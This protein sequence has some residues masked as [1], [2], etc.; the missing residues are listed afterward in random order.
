MAEQSSTK[1]VVAA[2]L[3]NM[4]IAVT[5]FGAALYTGSSAML[6]EAV[7]S[8]VDTGNQALL[9]F[10]LRRSR[11]P[12]DSEHPFG[13][14]ME[15]YFWAFVVAVLFFA[16]GAG[17]SIYEGVSKVIAPHPV[18]DPLVNYVVLAVSAVFEASAGWVAFKE[19]RKVKGNLGIFEA[20]HRSKNPALFTV[21]FEDSAALLGL[22]VAGAGIGASQIFDMPVFDG[23]AS[24]VIGAVLAVA[25]A[26]LAWE[27]KGL[28]IGEGA[29]PAVI[30]GI[31]GIASETPGV[32]KVNE[33]LTMHLGPEDVLLNLSL[34]FTDDL[35]ARDVEATISALETRIK[36]R[37]PEITRVF[38]EAQSWSAHRAA[39][40]APAE[41]KKQGA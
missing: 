40:K 18:T 24:L 21:L 25:A 33:A 7:H 22:A 41:K 19:F 39:A 38:I 12:A 28:L 36:A 15:L 26:I 5:K 3:G 30:R 11:R 35:S 1:V 10:G 34:D 16:V 13:Y 32:G 31:R 9:L 8:V 23:V 2:L 37:Y 27:C 20:V 29:R 6:S 14:G 4:L 17:V